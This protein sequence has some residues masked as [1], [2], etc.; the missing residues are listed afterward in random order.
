MA[1]GIAS[2]SP[3]GTYVGPA[4]PANPS[5]LHPFPLFTGK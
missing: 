5:P 1:S 3:S 4:H 2:E